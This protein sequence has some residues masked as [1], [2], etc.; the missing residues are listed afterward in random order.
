V[1][2]LL[3][4]WHIFGSEEL[5]ARAPAVAQRIPEP[6]I[7]VAT[8]D[9]TSRQWAS[10]DWLD[11]TFPGDASSASVL[12]LPLIVREELPE[13]VALLPAGLP[14][15]PFVPLPVWAEISKRETP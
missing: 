10:G 9:A 1:W 15:L 8:A 2:L 6:Y 7:A 4:A 5:S 3:P 13:G 14:A 11:V 12:T